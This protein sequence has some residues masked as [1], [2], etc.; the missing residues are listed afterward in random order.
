MMRLTQQLL[1]LG[2]VAGAAPFH[3]RKP[4]RVLRMRGASDIQLQYD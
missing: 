1:Q 4:L 2:Q 3:L